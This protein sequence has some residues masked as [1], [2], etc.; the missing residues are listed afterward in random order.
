[1]AY[2]LRSVFKGGS[3][4]TIGQVGTSA[5]G[6]F[7]IPIYTRFLSPGEYGVVGYL[8][9]LLQL[10]S[11]ILMFGF[12]GAQ[13]R[14][15]YEFKNEDRRIGEFLFSIN[16]YLIGLLVLICGFLTFWGSY[17]YGLLK[18]EDIP[19]YPYLPIVIWTAFFQIINQMVVS[20]YLA[21]KQFK[22]CALLQFLQF[23][24]M[25]AM[26][27]FFV[28]Y[29]K[30]GA[31]GKVKGHLVG[32][33]AFFVLFYI[34]Y[35]RKFVPRFD[36][37][38]VKYA[39][40]FGIPIVFH[41]LAVV[42]HNSIDRV[43]LEKYVTMEQL[44]IYSL[45]YQIGMVMSIIV[46]AVN[47]A[48]QPNYFDLMASDRHDKEYE[49]RR[50]FALWLVVIGSICLIGMLW[51]KE[52]LILFTPEDYHAADGVVP[53]IILGY[54]FQ[55][56]YFFAVSPIFQFKKTKVLPFLTGAA[57]LLN[58]SLNFLLIPRFGIYGAAYATLI[59]FCFQSV[60]VYFVSRR[61]YN[62]NFE[63]AKI[64]L[65][66]ILLISV[67]VTN[68]GLE[69]NFEMQLFKAIYFCGFVLTNFFL[70][71]SYTMPILVRICLRSRTDTSDG[72]A[73]G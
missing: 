69:I 47:N 29:M 50:I 9:V 48:W 21:S 54:F 19:F 56:V 14:Y 41:L 6:F 52:F 12:Y 46:I 57:A 66:V 20:Y 18:V 40:G 60:F 73:A 59:S 10:M 70:F 16:M 68:I 53:I 13:T 42:L 38:Y 51:A 36:K 35:F 5:L 61:L 55:G 58:I 43:I 4:Y 17:I 67:P 26:I 63:V 37:Q 2:S 71:K 32:Q 1:M 23:A 8:H 22:E 45:G 11:T 33:M 7:L 24:F 49:N 65:V 72:A 64:L 44:G 28:V 27:L 3:V 39:L 15:Y 30:E 34:P 25:T 31:L 62:P